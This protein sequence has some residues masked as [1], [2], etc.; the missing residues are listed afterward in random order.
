MHIPPFDNQNKPIVDINDS[1]VPLTYF[2]ILKLKKG[3]LF[4]YQ[5]P[6]Y[7]TCIVPA[8]VCEN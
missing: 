6:G 8:T 7:E 5:I 2:N 3:E 1:N 4:S